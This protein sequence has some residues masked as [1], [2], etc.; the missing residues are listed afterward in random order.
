MIKAEG[1]PVTSHEIM[2]ICNSEQS[3]ESKML[4]DPHTKGESRPRYFASL[5][6]TNGLLRRLWARSRIREAR[7]ERSGRAFLATILLT[8]LLT[9]LVYHLNR[10]VTLDV[11][12]L[13]DAPFV[14]DFY[15][16]ELDV[17]YRYRWTRAESVVAFIGA[18]SADAESVIVRAQPVFMPDP[19]IEPGLIVEF[20]TGT[21]G[22]HEPWDLKTITA[23]AEG[24]FDYSFVPLY[25]V[26]SG[27]FEVTLAAK[28]TRPPGDA[29]DLGVKVDRVSLQ[30]SGKGLNLPPL[31][32]L[33]WSVVLVAGV[34]GLFSGLRWYIAPIAAAFS[35]LLLA[36]ALAANSMYYAVYMPLIAV[37][38]GGG[39]LLAW[40]RRWLARWPEAV[41]W[42][43]RSERLAPALMLVAMFVYGVVSLTV[44]ARSDWIGHADYAEN[45]VVARNFVQGRGLVVDYVAQF[46]KEYPGITHPAETWPLLQPLMIVPFFAVFDAE[47]RAAKL[48]N[49]FVMLGLAWMVYVFASRLWDRRVG[50][51][52]GL[53]T[54]AHPYFFNS[55]LYPIND[56]PF[57]ALFFGLAWL[58]WRWLS[59]Y[60]GTESSR[61]N[62]PSPD[63]TSN[64]Q[65]SSL[66]LPPKNWEAV[67]IGALAGLLVWCKPSGAVL[68]A[69]LGA[70]GVWTW[71]RFHRP[72]GERIPW[73]I[74]I[75]AGVVAILVLSPLLVRNLL[76][77]GQP[78]FTTESYDAAILRYWNGDPA[79]WEPI[80]SVYAGGEL[81][82]PR[83]VIGGKFG[84]DA[85]FD[86]VGRNVRWVWERGA[87]GSPGEGDYVLGLLPLGL[88]ALGLAG[89]TRRVANLFS[90]VGVAIGVYA[91]FVLVYWHYE[92]RYF[93]VVVPWLL[94]LAAWGVFW[95]WDR[96]REGLREG[97]GREWSLLLLP[98]AL[99]LLFGPHLAVIREQADRDTRPT[100]F[101]ATMRWLRENSTPQDVIMTR[102]PWELNW[103]TERK[104]VMIPYNDLET[105]KRVAAQYGVTMLQ[106]GGPVDR[107]NPDECPSELVALPSYPTGSR[108]ALGSLYC[109]RELPGFRLVYKEGGGTI[110]R[111]DQ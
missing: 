55:A 16:D 33:L 26:P 71:L 57:T 99:I 28:T 53:L 52:A 60:K 6:R 97:V 46:Y 102:D 110:Y 41:D 2:L 58:V 73:R 86:A 34:F 22:L 38:V 96:L 85:L 15:G 89:L 90:M 25:S 23:Q 29:R 106:L 11:G 64:L 62:V 94:M 31:Y 12:D 92:G 35:A 18:G 76:T 14:R 65:P 9:L 88:A 47:T 81:P 17:A 8:L 104:A 54:L 105:I 79:R 27:S 63:G 78:Y 7:L 24:L 61:L 67:L 42:L 5:R 36:G 45:A 111:L 75:V 56:L 3:E 91:A 100:G 59:P 19:A 82:H 43:G 37:L 70:W 20:V 48:P 95:V 30:Q 4:R 84:Y 44:I 32:V 101:A 50:L 108:P 83:W 109:G 72:G 74:L 66:I 13:A 51:L 80:Y 1:G 49:V 107:I 93:Q 98:L 87:L 10:T 39:G 21:R 103:Y 68:L 77:F 69:G 40:G